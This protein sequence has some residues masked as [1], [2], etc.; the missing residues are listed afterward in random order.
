M[1]DVR[2]GFA[3]ANLSSDQAWALDRTLTTSELATAGSKPDARSMKHLP[4]VHNG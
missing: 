2:L 4:S 1:V 3:L